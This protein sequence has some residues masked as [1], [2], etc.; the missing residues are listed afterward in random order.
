MVS[1]L[2]TAVWRA[3]ETTVAGM[4][5]GIFPPHDPTQRRG[6]T[7]TVNGS[8]DH[9]K[10]PSRAQNDDKLMP[11]PTKWT[12]GQGLS[13][14]HVLYVGRYLQRGYSYKV[15]YQKKKFFFFLFKFPLASCLTSTRSDSKRL[16]HHRPGLVGLPVDC[17]DV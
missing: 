14:V 16:L 13:Y 6:G 2:T 10:N 3:A 12:V 4:R 7:G 9:S 11:L 17:S 15:S 1:Q 8:Q 5:T